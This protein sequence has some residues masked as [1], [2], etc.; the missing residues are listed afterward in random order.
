MVRNAFLLNLAL[1]GRKDLGK[2]KKYCSTGCIGVQVL[3]LPVFLTKEESR[4]TAN[5]YLFIINK[6]VLLHGLHWRTGPLPS[7]KNDRVVEW[8]PVQIPH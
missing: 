7:V 5:P 2:Q 4:N 8:R 6:K 1:V 3:Y